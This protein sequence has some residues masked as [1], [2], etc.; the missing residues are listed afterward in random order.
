MGLET[1][2]LYMISWKVVPQKS[3]LNFVL[4]KS[5]NEPNIGRWGRQID[6]VDMVEMVD[7]VRV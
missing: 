7:T 6:T 5:A 3:I 2:Q 4:C 1:G